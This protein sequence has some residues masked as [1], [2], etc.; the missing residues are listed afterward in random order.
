MK[1]QIYMMWLISFFKSLIKNHCF[2]E[3]PMYRENQKDIII[4]DFETTYLFEF[5]NKDL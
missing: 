2:R 4:E 5:D 3:K 1:Q